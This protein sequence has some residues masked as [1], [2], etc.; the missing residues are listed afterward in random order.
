MTDKKIEELITQD[1]THGFVTNVEQDTFPVGLNLNTISKISERKSEPKFMLK[2]RVEAYQKWI[3]MSSPSWSWP[4]SP[5]PYYL[6]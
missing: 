3:K 1:Y 4:V 2:W 6:L 5:W